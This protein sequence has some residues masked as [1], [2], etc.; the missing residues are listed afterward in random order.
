MAAPKLSEEARTFIVQSLAMF[1][2]P[3]EVV[4]AIKEQYGVTIARQSVQDYDPTIGKKPAKR[5]CALFEETRRRFLEETAEIPIA[6]RAVRLRRLQ[7]MAFTAESR[8]NY[9]LAAQL[10]EQAAKE[11]GG[12]YTNRREL[13]GRDGAPLIPEASLDD[14][15][16]AELASLAAKLAGDAT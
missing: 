2:T 4:E 16:D 13:T 9:P 6:N 8:R 5:W 1:D 7:R 14:L 10:L 11:T 3:S 12:I 15:S